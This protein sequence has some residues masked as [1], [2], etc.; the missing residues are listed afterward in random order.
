MKYGL[1]GVHT[2]FLKDKTKR[3]KK[4]KQQLFFKRPVKRLKV[5][6]WGIILADHISN[7]D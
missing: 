3:K 4:K 2:F 6:N 7:I 5:T 1:T